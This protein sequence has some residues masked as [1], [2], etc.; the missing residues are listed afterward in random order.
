M[1]NTVN[2]AEKFSSIS[3]YWHPRIVA[4]LNEN[5]IKLVKVKGEFVW[6]KHDTEDELFLVVKGRLLIRLR[7]RDLW[8]NDG[9][10]AVIPKGVEH[11]PVAEEE[12]HILLLEPK[13]TV[14]TGD[15]T[16]ERMVEASEWV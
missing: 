16:N 13:T 15:V 1:S 5:Y 6:H 8:L 12:V 3:D 7:D 10:L 14:N 11:C 2:L 9:E 4:E